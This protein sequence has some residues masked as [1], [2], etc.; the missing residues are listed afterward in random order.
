MRG[1]EKSLSRS[2][3]PRDPFRL[4]G[5]ASQDG[6]DITPPEMWDTQSIEEVEIAA[7]QS[8]SVDSDED[9]PSQAIDARHSSVAV[10]SSRYGR[11]VGCLCL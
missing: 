10:S 3:E 4:V 7:V 11:V 9:R 1:K 6:V 8:E 2:R 5:T